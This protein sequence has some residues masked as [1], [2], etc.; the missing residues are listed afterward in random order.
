MTF[1]GGLFAL[2][3][4]AGVNALYGLFFIKNYNKANTATFTIMY[5]FYKIFG[6]GI[7]AMAGAI[8]PWLFIPAVLFS[9]NYSYCGYY[10]CFI[11][12]LI[13]VM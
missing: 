8:N 5:M 12:V 6:I 2:A 3:I 4:M 11:G 13:G 7:I 9:Y 1:L 10:A